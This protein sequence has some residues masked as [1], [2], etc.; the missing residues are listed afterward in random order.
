MNEC[1][2]CPGGFFCPVSEDELQPTQPI[3]CKSGNYCEY[4][5]NNSNEEVPC[6][7]GT[8]NPTFRSNDSLS[9][10][11]C[12][13]GYYCDTEGIA[14][15]SSKSCPDGFYCPG[16]SGSIPG[17]INWSY[18]PIPCPE[19]YY[20]KEI[21]PGTV[22]LKAVEECTLCPAGYFCPNRAMN[23]TEQ[24]NFKCESGAFCQE[25]SARNYTCPAGYYCPGTT[26]K[27]CIFLFL[28]SKLTASFDSASPISKIQT[29]K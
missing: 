28:I 16:S 6:P 14:E 4:G 11:P 29:L 18:N 8:F 20:G 2:L 26:S 3:E 24:K 12:P 25:G 9:C 5:R 10:Q 21:R 1:D 23:S 13:A 17:D 22:G 15:L 27:V 19:G 7:V